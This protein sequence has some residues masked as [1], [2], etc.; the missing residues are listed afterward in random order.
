MNTKSAVKV[1]VN[2]YIQIHERELVHMH[3]FCST[4][5]TFHTQAQETKSE[6]CMRARSCV[7]KIPA[8]RPVW[9][10]LRGSSKLENPRTESTASTKEE[11]PFEVRLINRRAK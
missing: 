9:P 11:Y 3:P 2:S 4:M 1:L 5:N 8:L 10:Q 7:D 6:N